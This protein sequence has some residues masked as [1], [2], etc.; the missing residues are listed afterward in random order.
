MIYRYKI[1]RLTEDELLVLGYIYMDTLIDKNL[2]GDR[3][4]PINRIQCLSKKSVIS[5]LKGAESQL[6]DEYRHLINSIIQK[7]ITF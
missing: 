2:I 4:L 1:N 5:K 7:L 3:R 6:R